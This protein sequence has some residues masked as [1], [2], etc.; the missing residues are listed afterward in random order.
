MIKIEV[1]DVSKSYKKETVLDHVSLT[2]ESGRIYGFIGKNGSGK[3]MLLKVICGFV[4]PTSGEVWVDGK[5]IGQD[6]DF[7][8]DT[9]VI[10][11]TPT[12]VSY[13]SGYQNLEK[14]AAIR[15]VIGKREIMDVLERV[16]LSAGNRKPVA[17]YS[18]GM[19][20]RLG[21]A[22]AIMEKPRL[23]VLDEPMNGL[24]EEGVADI[25]RLLLE[26]KAEGVTI[27]MASHNREDIAL[28]CDAVYEM[29]RGK[30]QN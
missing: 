17:K 16:G 14:L 11:E 1:K 6:V 26:M 10:I 9:G 13:L 4:S 27:L 7:P 24:D 2:L 30:I 15:R 5:R 18:L 12:F 3:T 21:I 23:L 8:E 25:R 28:L 29:K 20:Q 22:Q 19:R